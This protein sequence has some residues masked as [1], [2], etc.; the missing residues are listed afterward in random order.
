MLGIRLRI[1]TSCTTPT[2]NSNSPTKIN[3]NTR[4]KF[5][6]LRYVFHFQQSVLI[7]VTDLICLSAWKLIM[8]AMVSLTPWRGPTS[9]PMLATVPVLS[10]DI[11]SGRPILSCSS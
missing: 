9:S 3:R 1:V 6:T 8:S 5:Q 7:D 2:T 11:N 10:R 4:T